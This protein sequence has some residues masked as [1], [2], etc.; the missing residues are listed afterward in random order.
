MNFS[1]RVLFH[2]KTTVCL[3][4]FGQ[5]CSLNGSSFCGS[6]NKMLNCKR[7]FDISFLQTDAL[8]ESSSEDLLTPTLSG[9][10][11][12]AKLEMALDPNAPDTEKE[13]VLLQQE[14]AEMVAQL[15]VRTIW[16]L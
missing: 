4:Y 14:L 8:P 1:P 9:D 2:R 15:K 5:D 7:N 13:V 3:K 10:Y 11:S 12:K 16:L 6:G